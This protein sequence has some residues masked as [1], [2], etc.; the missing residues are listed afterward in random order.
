[1]RENGLEKRIKVYQ[2]A[3]GWDGSRVVKFPKEAYGMPSFGLREG[4]CT[5]AL[6]GWSWNRLLQF[7]VDEEVSIVKVD[8][9]GCERHLLS[10]DEDL[11]VKI[12]WWLIEVHSKDLCGKLVDMFLK[13]G[14]EVCK[15]YREYHGVHGYLDILIFKRG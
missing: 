15:H 8:C 14:Y 10:A 4:S 3:I 5:V 2:L 1:M 13:L 12:P 7:A 11:I 9:E 6:E